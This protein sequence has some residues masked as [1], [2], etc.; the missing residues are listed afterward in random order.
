MTLLQVKLFVL[1]AK[2]GN[3]SQA[4]DSLY[5]SQSSTS[6]YISSLESE[7]GFQ[8]FNRTNKSVTLTRFGQEFYPYAKAL[9]NAEND[10]NDF[11][12]SQ[13]RSRT[14]WVIGLTDDLKD[15]TNFGF[16]RAY[17]NA[18]HKFHESYA[19]IHIVTRFYPSQELFSLLSAGKADCAIVP[20]CNFKFEESVPPSSKF[21]RLTH[22]PNYL[23]LPRNIPPTPKL[24][25]IGQKLRTVYY[26]P[27]DVNHHL[28]MHLNRAMRSSPKAYPCAAPMELLLRMSAYEAG[29]AALV[30]QHLVSA[31]QDINMP[32]IPLDE[33]TLGSGLY[34]FWEQAKEPE[35]LETF[36]TLIEKYISLEQ[37]VSKHV[38]APSYDERTNEMFYQRSRI[39][40]EEENG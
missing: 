20:V 34:L 40:C 30:E 5:I 31:F 12:N 1:V 29:A 24:E 18:L 26:L 33:E 37:Q 19:D 4:S 6:K 36:C 3:F 8:L 21:F 13:R 35:Q 23:I 17:I 10:V 2:Y 9:I 28:L 25:K 22:T 39:A 16:F 27:N 7:L 14:H 15:G 32:I 38:N 11:V